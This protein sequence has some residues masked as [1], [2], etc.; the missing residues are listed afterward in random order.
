MMLSCLVIFSPLLDDQ[1][2]DAVGRAIGYST[3]ATDS[4]PLRSVATRAMEIKSRQRHSVA[5]GA[6]RV[7][8]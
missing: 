8:G 6:V 7:S 1:V 4:F 5:V 3:A 2:D